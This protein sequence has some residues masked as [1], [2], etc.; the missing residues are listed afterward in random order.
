MLPVTVFSG[1][2][3]IQTKNASKKTTMKKATILFFLFL[4]ILS[5]VNAQK[6]DYKQPI[7]YSKVDP[8]RTPTAFQS[9]FWYNTTSGVLWRYDK[10]EVSWAEYNSRAYAEMGISNDTLSISFAAT[11]PDTLEGMTAGNL[12]GFTLNSDGDLLTYTGATT[13]KFLLTYSASFTFA[14]AVPV[15]AYIVKSGSV[16]YMSRTR[17]LP[18]TA[19]NTV[20]V[21]GTSIVSLSQGQT[22]ALFF[23]PTTHSG[24]DA[25]TVYE[26][27]VS[28]V[29]IE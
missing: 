5:F 25:L 28:L 4:G 14:E 24:T 19:G 23:V 3:Y 13:K 7:S 9:H 16:Q 11:T 26:A 6:V 21:S 8:T 20:N 15:W 18:A 17:V 22:I 10:A 27:N 2:A 1:R 29:E 12:S